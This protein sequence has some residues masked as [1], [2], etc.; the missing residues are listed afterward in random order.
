MEKRMI[1]ILPVGRD[2]FDGNYRKKEHDS[3]RI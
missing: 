3:E 1:C 2:R